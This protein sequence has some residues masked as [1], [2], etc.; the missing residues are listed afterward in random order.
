MT[1]WARQRT[2][3]TASLDGN[4]Q[5][6][7]VLRMGQQEEAAISIHGTFSAT[8]ELQRS[9]DGGDTWKPI[10]SK[11]NNSSQQTA[12]IDLDYKAPCQMELR[13]K[14]TSY[15]SGTVGVTMKKG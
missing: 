3:V 1:T 5:N 12:E 6:S 9:L 4:G 15:T 14:V 8:V 7:G 2:T 13:V 11:E 10:T